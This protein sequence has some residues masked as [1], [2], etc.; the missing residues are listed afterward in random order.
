LNVPAGSLHHGSIVKPP[1]RP[2]AGDDDIPSMDV[3]RAL[4]AAG[5]L[6]RAW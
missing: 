1:E 5:R 6:L 2:H 4:H 3:L